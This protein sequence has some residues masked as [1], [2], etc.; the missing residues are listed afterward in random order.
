[1]RVV[2]RVAE[3]PQCPPIGTA[4]L[5]WGA[6]ISNLAQQWQLRTLCFHLPS[7]GCAGNPETV[8]F[9]L[10]G[11]LH[12]FFTGGGDVVPI[13]H[14][15]SARMELDRRGSGGGAVEKRSFVVKELKFI[16]PLRCGECGG[17]AH[18]TRRSPDPVK[19]DGSEIRVFECYE[20][21]HQ[22]NRTVKA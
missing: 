1:M 17:N 19:R 22:T 21:G 16:R 18:L 4:R 15:L 11:L 14:L 12:S 2:R 8:E 10:S 7:P 3:R 6:T 9:H 13:P 5:R 20:C